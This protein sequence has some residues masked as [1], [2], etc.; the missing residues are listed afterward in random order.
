[1]WGWREE[2]KAELQ[3]SVE[4]RR[5]TTMVWQGQVEGSTGAGVR[6]RGSMGAEVG[7]GDGHR[8]AESGATLAQ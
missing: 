2:E 6:G 8:E 1:V 4:L 5:T 3:G 7:G